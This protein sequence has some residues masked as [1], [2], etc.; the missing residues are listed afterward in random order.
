MDP[1]APALGV[2]HL[3]LGDDIATV[4]H[5]LRDEHMPRAADGVRRRQKGLCHVPIKI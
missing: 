2:H 1:A 3:R 5:W 4:L